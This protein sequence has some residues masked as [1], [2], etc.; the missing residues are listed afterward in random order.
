M[1]LKYELNGTD[2]ELL[3]YDDKNLCVVRERESV[4]VNGNV[5]K[6][7]DILGYY[8]SVESGAI[9]FRKHISLDANADM[10]M[11]KNLNDMITEVLTTYDV[12]GGCITRIKVLGIKRDSI[13]LMEREEKPKFNLGQIAQKAPRRAVKTA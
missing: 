3:R 4:D 2:Y 6:K 12:F 10:Q 1:V 7:R 13:P 5:N 11:L 8:P 9:A